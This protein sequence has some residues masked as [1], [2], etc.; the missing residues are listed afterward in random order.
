MHHYRR[1]AT[2]V[3]TPEAF[4]LAERIASWHDA[5][6][7]H[8]RVIRASGEGCEELDPCPHVEADELWLQ[9]R[10]IFGTAADGFV[11]L[12]SRALKVPSA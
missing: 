3:G 5:M 8:E 2:Q 12:R 4:D 10:T 7:T 9:A 11:F 6:V 1:I